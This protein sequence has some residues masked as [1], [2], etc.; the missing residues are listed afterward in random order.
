M[1]VEWEKVTINI[2]GHLVD[3]VSEFIISETS[4]GVEVD[5]SSDHCSV[6]AWLMQE[7]MHAGLFEKIKAFVRD[8]VTAS[9]HGANGIEVN[10]EGVQDLD[11]AEKWKKFFRPVRIGKQFVIKPRWEPFEAE[12]RDIVIEIDPGQAFGVGTHASTALMLEGIEWVWKQMPWDRAPAVL[13]VGTGTGILGIAAAKKGAR[14]VEAVDID[15]EAVRTAAENAGLNRVGHV[16]NVSDRSLHS[17][18]Q[19]FDLIL[20]NIDRDTLKNLASGLTDVLA[21]HGILMVSGILSN[22]QAEIA[23]VFEALGLSLLRSFAGSGAGDTDSDEW[24]CMILTNQ[25]L[26]T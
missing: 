4:R 24:A 6:I 21:Q 17:F 26:K 1:K 11:W 18:S 25:H 19:K 3:I 14:H 2:P 5:D 20:A 13:D 22:Q 10:H 8:H 16:M 15:P 9:E 12:D 23:S 7:E